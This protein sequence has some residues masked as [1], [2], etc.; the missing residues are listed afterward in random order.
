MVYTCRQRATAS[1][2][3]LL[4]NHKADFSEQGKVTSVFCFVTVEANKKVAHNFNP[5]FSYRHLLIPV[6]RSSVSQDPHPC[7]FT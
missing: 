7:V 2:E 5:C 4:Q 6:C 3:D 1:H